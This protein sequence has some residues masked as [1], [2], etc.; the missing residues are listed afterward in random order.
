MD[1]A[2][3]INSPYPMMLPSSPQFATYMIERGIR[4]D[5]VLVIYD[6]FETGLRL[7]P[8]VAWTCKYFGHKNVHVLDNFTRYVNEGFPVASGPIQMSVSSTTS[9]MNH[10]TNSYP[11]PNVD[12]VITFEHL[13]RMIKDPSL[14]EKFQIIDARPNDLFSGL[15]TAS[16][17][18]S[19]VRLGHM[20]SAINV[21]FGSDLGPDKTFLPPARLRDLFLKAGVRED[22][23]AMLTCNTGVTAAVIDL[24]LRVAG[25]KVKTRLYDGSWSE[26]ADRVDEHGLIVI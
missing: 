24:A 14:K 15:G 5:D 7:S 17:A 12:N 21:P 13:R 4:P 16:G 26:W 22:V 2:K 25:L 9:V 19:S 3:D 18:T 20:P 10:T 6:S 8:R 23:P 11:N 1:A